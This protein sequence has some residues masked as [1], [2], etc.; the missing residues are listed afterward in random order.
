MVESWRNSIIF[1]PR[2]SEK[3]LHIDELSGMMFRWV[4]VA[5]CYLDGR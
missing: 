5:F 4:S 3:S 1:G 2:I